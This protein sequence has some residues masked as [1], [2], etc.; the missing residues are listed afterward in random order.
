MNAGA[1]ERLAERLGEWKADAL[2][3][4][5]Q[6]NIRY[7]TGFTG[8][9]G[10]L[11]VAPSGMTLF[12]DPRYAIQAAKQAPCAV[13]VVR[14]PL[15]KAAAGLVRRKRWRRVGFEAARIFFTDYTALRD[16]LPRGVTLMPLAPVVEPLRMV[17]TE[18]EI[19]RIRRSV[20]T[21]SLALDAALPAIRPGVTELDIAAEL[22]YQQRR[23]GAEKA[24]FETIVAAGPRSALPHA[25]PGTQPVIANHLLLID[26]G[27]CQ[28]GYASDMTRV[29]A[30]GQPAARLRDM[31][32][33]VHEAQW[34]ATEA[35]RPGVTAGYIDGQARRVM[36]A[37]GLDRV[38]VHST[39]HG[40]G[41]E[42]HEAPRLGAKDQTKLEAG[43]VVTIEPGAYVEGLGGVRIEDTVLVTA[44]GHE[45]LTPTSKEFISL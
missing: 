18:E 14:G 15:A 9:N 23:H 4:S 1:A 3:I 6:A 30:I 7:L 43:M 2:L 39:G 42:I 10:L 17:K 36:K 40:L 22:E 21:N 45:T 32:K 41:L 26:M 16:A 31:H 20:M 29:F 33:A 24:A 37:H 12:T 19:A 38:F 34:A 25:E 28:E 13:R 35:V 44:T 27:A 5:A 11:A 8:S